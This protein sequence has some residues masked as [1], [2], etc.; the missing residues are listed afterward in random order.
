[1]GTAPRFRAASPAQAARTPPALA[2]TAEPR[3]AATAGLGTSELRPQ[4]LAVDT[5]P[6]SGFGAVAAQLSSVARTCSASTSARERTCPVDQPLQ[7]TSG[8]ASAP[9]P[10]RPGGPHATCDPVHFR[11]VARPRDT[12]RRGRETASDSDGRRSSESRGRRGERTEKELREDPPR[13]RRGQ[14]QLPRSTA[15]V[16][17]GSTTPPPTATSSAASSSLSR[18]RRRSNGCPSVAP[19]MRARRLLPRSARP[20]GTPGRSRT[21]PPEPA[22]PPPHCARNQPGHAKPHGRR[23]SRTQRAHAAGPP[24][25]PRRSA[26]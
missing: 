19:S 3:S 2:G 17:A 4:R 16:R 8:R 1:M 26:A 18:T 9:P 5:E 20:P 10:V 15:G 14:A 6:T 7:A 13:D 11:E 25:P 21:A 23:L 12:R 22:F 24:L